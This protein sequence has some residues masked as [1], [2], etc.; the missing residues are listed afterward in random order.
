MPVLEVEI[1]Q[2]CQFIKKSYEIC[3]LPQQYR[4]CPGGEDVPDGRTNLKSFRVID[5]LHRGNIVP[6]DMSSIC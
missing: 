3:Y 1:L 2:I 4:V 6:F 5:S